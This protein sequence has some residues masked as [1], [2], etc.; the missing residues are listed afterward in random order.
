[1]PLASPSR[2]FSFLAGLCLLGCGVMHAQPATLPLRPLLLECEDMELPAGWTRTDSMPGSSGGAFLWSVASESD[3]FTVI[4]VEA[5]GRYDVWSRAWD[6]ADNEPGTRRFL[7][8]VNGRPMDRESGQHKTHGFAWEKV[9]TVVLSAGR[10]V[11]GLRDVTKHWSRPDAILLAPRGFDPSKKKPADLQAYRVMPVPVRHTLRMEGT[12]P[13]SAPAAGSSAWEDATTLASIESDALRMSFVQVG[14]PVSSSGAAIGRRL[15][16]KKDGRWVPLPLNPGAESLFVLHVPGASKLNSSAFIPRWTPPSPIVFTVNGRDYDIGETENPFLAGN[17]TTLRPVSVRGEKPGEISVTYE[18][19]GSAGSIRAVGTWTLDG[20]AQRLDLAFETPAAGNWSVGFSPFQG[21]PRSAVGFVQQ[22]PLFQM[23]RLP[24]TPKMTSSATMP[25]PMSLVQVSPEGLGFPLSF[26]VAAPAERMPFEWGRRANSPYGFSILNNHGEVQGTA[27]SPV[28]GMTGSELPAGRTLR[29]GFVAHCL[30]SDW[31]GALA[32]LSDRVFRVTD[33][34]EPVAA[35]LTGAALNMI[36]LIKNADASGWD[37]KLRGHYNIESES[38]VTQSSPLTALSVARLTRDPEFY[39]T[40]AL[41]TLEFTLSRAGVH[42]ATKPTLLYVPP[43]NIPLVAPGS[44]RGFGPRY[45]HGVHELTARLNPWVRSLIPDVAELS[46]RTGSP[47]VP[48]WSQ[49]LADYQLSP[50]PEKLAVIEAACDQWIAETLHGRHETPLGIMP[51]YNAAFYPYWWD[52]LDLHAITGREK[53][54]EAAVEG[55]FHT[56]SGLWSHPLAPAG[57]TTVHP[58]GE[59]PGYLLDHVYWKG[60]EPYRLGYPRRPGDMPERKVPAWRVSR[61]GLGLEQ[62]ITLYPTNSGTTADVGVGNI[63]NN[64]WAPSLLRLYGLTGRELFRTYA[65]N[66]IIGRFANYPGYYVNNFTDVSQYPE[67][68]YKGPDVTNIYYHHIPVHLAFTL[69]YIFTEAET[70]SGGAVKFPW[71]K[72]QG[73]V[74]FTNRIYGHAPGSVYGDD[75]LWPWLD[76]RAF[77]VDSPQVN[78][79]GAVGGGKLR[80]VVANS[81]RREARASLSLDLARIGVA[82]GSV[83]HFLVDGREAFAGALPPADRLADG[84]RAALPFTLPADAVGVFCFDSDLPDGAPAAPPLR[85]GPVRLDLPEPW[86]RLHALRIRS[87]FGF[88]SLYVYAEKMPPAGASLRLRFSD[89]ARP[90]VVVAAAPYEVTVDTVP[91]AEA[92]VF[93]VEL[94]TADGRNH[95]TPPITL[96]GTP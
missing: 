40:R 2:F 25:H 15:E 36:D 41:P 13:E 28:L 10:Q 58:G 46:R 30:P 48:F 61:V 9:G 63:F 73:Y 34:R 72:Q 45:W 71:V 47:L 27:F 55:G 93:Q 88:D 77:S 29:V 96:P 33:Y 89:P 83:G 68:P 95:T 64:A 57:D 52:L 26:A 54:L 74:W 90:P 92:A 21:W 76:R 51:F 79:F 19:A 80:I 82:P 53:Y 18:G 5:G 50:S 8:M 85:T 94:S 6:F 70:L 67:Y 87:P 66:T 81:S 24:E 17:R 69:D 78:Y 32:D 65:R 56:V 91:M 35:S 75:G 43:S 49:M 11:I 42:H 62:P 14:Q 60:A 23:Q 39:T 22:P 84:V 44:G 7:V 59:Y 4:E 12:A 1:M 38:T 37:A 16:I 31:T 3:A 86:G 20:P